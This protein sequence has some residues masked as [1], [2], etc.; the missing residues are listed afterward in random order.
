VVV[1]SAP[2]LP[3]SVEH[4]IWQ[5]R[6]MG[7]LAGVGQHASA[8]GCRVW[9]CVW[10][11]GVHTHVGVGMGLGFGVGLSVHTTWCWVAALWCANSM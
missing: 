4:G 9:L 1:D 8:C 5:S 6:G 3:H 7:C 10:V 11:L 2:L